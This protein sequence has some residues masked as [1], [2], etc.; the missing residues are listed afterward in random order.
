MDVR[1]ISTIALALALPGC[2]SP[3]DALD[4]T[5]S[6]SDPGG[7]T[8]TAAG[9]ESGTPNGESTG[10]TT[11][12]STTGSTTLDETTT[13][14]GMD[15]T[16]TSDD[17]STTG[18]PDPMAVCGDGMVEG[19][20]D[21]DDAELNGVSGMS[22]C[23]EDC[24]LT[25][26]GDGFP[27]LPETEECDQGDN[28]ADDAACTAACAV[29]VCGDELVGPGESCD[30]GKE[31]SELCTPGC[32]LASCGDGIIQAGEDCDDENETSTDACVNCV[33]ASCGDGFVEAGE[34]QC[35]DGA[36]NASEPIVCAY[37]VTD[38]D[39]TYCAASSCSVEQ[40]I[41]SF[42]GDGI[43]QEG[44][45]EVCDGDYANAECSDC[46]GL[47]CAEGYADCD[48]SVANG[49][50]I[51]LTTTAS[52]CGTCGHSCLGGECAAGECQP[53]ALYASGGIEDIV[54]NEDSVFFTTSSTLEAIPQEPT[55]SSVVIETGLEVTSAS[56]LEQNDLYVVTDWG[57]N[58]VNGEVVRISKTLGGTLN[59]YDP[60][61]EP[62]EY[63]FVNEP[64]LASMASN[65][66]YWTFSAFDFAG[67]PFEYFLRGAA[68][69][70]GTIRTYVSAS[71]DPIG[72]VEATSSTVFWAQSG[73]TDAIL[74]RPSSGGV[75]DTVVRSNLTSCNSIVASVD[76]IYFSCRDGVSLLNTLFAAD[77][78]GG[79][80]VVLLTEEDAHF[81]D[82]TN[83]QLSGDELVW[84]DNDGT[85]AAPDR[86]IRTVRIDGTE[87][88]T[89]R[90]GVFAA[91][92]SE[93][94]F[95]EASDEIWM[96]AK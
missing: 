78:D 12:E 29:A 69:N 68:I 62:D 75:F 43:V 1:R 23:L 87:A 59:L 80:E 85:I 8:T 27:G 61:N 22:D 53:Y 7:T 38:D 90:P 82:G 41:T 73:D 71:P 2:F 19:E 57:T 34:E 83:L 77:F 24:T 92:D 17:P 21:C 63:G 15:D 30:D 56:A 18:E 10:T 50:E 67:A 52:S 66:V 93:A 64:E 84:N 46:G 32:V 35:D 74:S 9:S 81:D 65:R 33:F 89:V 51:D 25:T 26:C 54:V 31:G 20:E 36:G 88:R 58:S 13:G 42:C 70:G 95:W 4:P 49:C 45:G 91:V 16:S 3:N 60:G 48:G 14:D 47:T 86:Y 11:P 39:C 96:L 72:P 76:R 55:A 44:N 37:G 28:N 5:E 40:G 94:Y 79:N 6:D